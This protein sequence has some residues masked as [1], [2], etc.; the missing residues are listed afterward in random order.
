[1]NII[2]A[3]TTWVHIR[4][5]LPLIRLKDE[6]KWTLHVKNWIMLLDTPHEYPRLHVKEFTR[7]N[8]FNRATRTVKLDIHV[9]GRRHGDSHSFHPQ[10]DRIIN[11]LNNS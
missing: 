10:I 2:V 3:R 8:P 6:F 1:M 11:M 4:Q 9:D 7:L 5:Q